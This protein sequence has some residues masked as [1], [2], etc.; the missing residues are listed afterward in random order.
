M[1]AVC[2][3]EENE[4]ETGSQRKVNLQRVTSHKEGSGP[5]GITSSR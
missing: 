2:R 1:S 4:P 5:G 3:S